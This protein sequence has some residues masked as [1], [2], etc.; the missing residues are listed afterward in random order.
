MSLNSEVITGLPEGDEETKSETFIY[1]KQKIN[2]T[3]WKISRKA[4]SGSKFLK[5]SILENP[6]AS[7]YGTVVNPLIIDMEYDTMPFIIRYLEHFVDK[8]DIPIPE[9][10]LKNVDI[11]VI[12]GN[13]YKLFIGIYNDDD[14]L[15]VKFEKLNTYIMS[16]VYFNIKNL[17]EV[18]CAIVASLVKNKTIEELSV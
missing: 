16:A 5:A 17:H 8:P 4:A 3:V 11:S 2:N 15:G 12:L 1:I 9:K 10:P 18:I 7:T 14:A 13:N 6:N